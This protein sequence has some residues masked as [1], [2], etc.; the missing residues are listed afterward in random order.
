MTPINQRLREIVRAIQVD[1]RP[2][3]EIARISGLSRTYLDRLDADGLSNGKNGFN[4]TIK[5]LIALEDTLGLSDPSLFLSKE[6]LKEDLV[7]SRTSEHLSRTLSISAINYDEELHKLYMYLQNFSVEHGPGHDPDLRLMRQMAPH[8]AVHLMEP[9]EDD[10]VHSVFTDWDYVPDFR[11]GND[12]TGAAIDDFGDKA[13]NQSFAA[14]VTDMLNSLWPHLSYV[15]RKSTWSE[16]GLKAHRRFLR[17]MAP[18]IGTGDR[19]KIVV[20]RRMQ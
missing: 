6:I 13:L 19:R 9:D 2:K 8:C 16:T 3:T 17:L 1:P 4:P 14:D 15:E 7:V 12:F 11:G 5:A 20:I 10:P 18:F